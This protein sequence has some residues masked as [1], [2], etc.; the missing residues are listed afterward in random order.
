MWIYWYVPSAACRGVIT[1]MALG[2]LKRQKALFKWIANYLLRIDWQ[3][4]VEGVKRLTIWSITFIT[5]NLKFKIALI[6]PEVGLLCLKF[7]MLVFS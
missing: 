6:A 7:K 5:F 2:L 1:E 3:T 4:R